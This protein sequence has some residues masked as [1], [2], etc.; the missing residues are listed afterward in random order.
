MLKE[1]FFITML[2]LFFGA[3]I[4]ALNEIKRDHNFYEN[5]INK[6]TR[7]LIPASNK[8]YY[9][10]YG[11]NNRKLSLYLKKHLSNTTK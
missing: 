6:I 9:E 4:E 1:T 2:V 5:S 10:S 7:E 3:S 11:T 8:E